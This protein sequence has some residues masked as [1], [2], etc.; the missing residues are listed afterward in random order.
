M[1]DSDIRFALDA[2]L[3][4]RHNGDSDTVI[5]HE[6]GLCAGKRR[7]DIAI[8]NS[9]IVGYEIKSDE[10][11]L[12]RLEGQAEVYGDV[13]DKAILV[14][15]ERHLDRALDKLPD[16]WGVT[17]AFT[18]KGTVCLKDIRKPGFNNRLDAFSLVQLLWRTE[19][20]EELRLRNKSQGLS[21]KARHYVWAA[22]TDAVSLDE[23]RSIVRSHLK[24]RQVWPGGQ[25]HGQNDVILPT[26]TS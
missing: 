11:T 24:A 10:D 26:I 15:T 17:I 13:L 12:N 5:R 18:K 16:W 9:E 21:K 2:L 22:L 7:I 14:T 8:I 20:L 4:E 1:R 19:A 6:V 3:R 23:L 25:L